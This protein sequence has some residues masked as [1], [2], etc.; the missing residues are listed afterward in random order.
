[1]QSQAFDCHS[2][3]KTSENSAETIKALEFFLHHY[4][5]RKEIFLCP[6]DPQ[7][8]ELSQWLELSWSESLFKKEALKYPPLL[9]NI[10]LSDLLHAC[11]EELI[12][13]KSHVCFWALSLK[14]QKKNVSPYEKR[15][16]KLL[17]TKK[18]PYIFMELSLDNKNSFNELMMI[19]YK[20]IFCMGDFSK[21]NIYIQPWVDY[22]KKV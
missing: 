15:I 20:I 3:P 17:Q 22:F 6:F 14:S 11:I 5:K 21:S 9:R 8:R 19:F 7:L 1:M 2:K 16:K 10:A 12:A 18:I 13:K 4:D